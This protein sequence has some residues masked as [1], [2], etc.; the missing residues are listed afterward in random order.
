L[1]FLRHSVD[2]SV[3]ELKAAEVRRTVIPNRKNEKQNK[4]KNVSGH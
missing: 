3:V 4:K 2:G 1:F